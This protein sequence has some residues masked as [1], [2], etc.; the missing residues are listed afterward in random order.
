MHITKST[1]KQTKKSTKKDFGTFKK[2]AAIRIQVKPLN[3]IKVFKVDCRK[4]TA[5]LQRMKNTQS[6]IKLIKLGKNFGTTY[7]LGCKDYLIILSHKKQN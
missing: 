1:E 2:I 4:K 7:C 6:E 3:K 5:R